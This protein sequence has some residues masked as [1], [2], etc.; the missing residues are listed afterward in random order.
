MINL[1]GTRT[2]FWQPK[3]YISK[4]PEKSEK[5]IKEIELIRKTQDS[6]FA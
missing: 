1:Q 6:K 4:A 3:F 2:D 5:K